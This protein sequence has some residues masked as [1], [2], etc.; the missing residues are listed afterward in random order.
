M[1]ADADQVKRKRLVWGVLFAWSPLIVLASFSFH[2]AFRGFAEQK[3]T[4][5]GAVAGGLSE[6]LALGFGVLGTIILEV[7]AIVLL[8]RSFSKE[9]FGRT[10]LSVLSLGCCGLTLLLLWFVLAR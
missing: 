2:Y 6:A 3:A 1:C 9:H 7:S 8:F 4:G 10:F 5:L